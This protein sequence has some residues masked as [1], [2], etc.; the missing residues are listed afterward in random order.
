MNQ[1][2]PQS[3][4]ERGS[5][6][7]IQRLVESQSE[8]L[9][10]EIRKAAKRNDDW[11]VEWVSPREADKWSEY[12]DAEFLKVVG[13]PNL[14]PDLASFWPAGGPQWDALGK[15]SDNG[16]VL[17]EAKA[18][19]GEMTSEC[20]AGESSAK[21]ID[22][23]LKAAKVAFGA[24]DHADWKSGYYQYAN[25]LAYLKFLRERVP[26]LLVFVY[27]CGDIEMGGP[28]CK[29]EWDEVLAAVHAH[30][31]IGSDLIEHGVLDAFIPIGALDEIG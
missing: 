17:V 4:A 21:K 2:N 8:L 24:P 9:T 15:S 29:E 12:R 11:T 5:Q 26:A 20:R 25:R 10:S 31:G 30:L 13:Y 16:I 27:F 6:K 19:T 22:D 7:W 28:A 1:R 3:L 18:H 23:A 14:A